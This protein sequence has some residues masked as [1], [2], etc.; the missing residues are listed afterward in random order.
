R[1]AAGRALVVLNQQTYLPLL[2]KKLADTNQIPALR[3]KLA[4]ILAELNSA[5]AREATLGA[6]GAAPRRLQIKLAQ[7]LAGNA[8]GADALLSLTEARKL[9]PQILLDR[10]VKE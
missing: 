4:G 5:A 8:A 9:S 10:V 7:T 1:A 2:A 6:L 3:E